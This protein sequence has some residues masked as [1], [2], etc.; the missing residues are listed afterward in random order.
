MTLSWNVSVYIQRLSCTAD[1]YM[2]AL[3]CTHECQLDLELH[4]LHKVIILYKYI[5]MTTSKSTVQINDQFKFNALA[6][7]VFFTYFTLSLMPPLVTGKISWILE[8]LEVQV[9][10]FRDKISTCLDRQV[11]QYRMKFLEVIVLVI[12][13]IK[14][15]NLFTRL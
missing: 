6:S 15:N 1:L 11:L 3:D 2:T 4:V 13:I 7:C 5:S 10:T 8:I 9:E 12:T 14:I